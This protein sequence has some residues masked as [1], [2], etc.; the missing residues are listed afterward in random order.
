MKLFTTQIQLRSI[1]FFFILLV[2]LANYGQSTK[3]LEMAN[4]YYQNQSWDKAL[5]AY[6]GITKQN[7]YNG[8]YWFK[9]GS[10][11][12][13]LN[14]YESSIDSYKQAVL[15]G[16]D[17]ATASY[18]IA[19]SYA[20]INNAKSAIYWLNYAISNGL[21]N[22]EKLLASDTDLDA[23]RSE[24]GFVKMMAPKIS[25][26]IDRNTGW[27][28]DI[29]YMKN[30]FERTH[31]NLFTL[32]DKEKWE[33]SFNSLCK[34]IDNLNDYE[35]IVTLME[36]T[37]S[38]GAG[39]SLV[40]PPFSG[41]YHFGQLPIEFYQFSDGI[42]V[43]KAKDVYK[44]IIGLEVVSIE[45]IPIEEVL[46][47]VRKVANP[48]NE[49]MMN[50]TGLFYSTLPEVLL[51]YGVITDRSKVSIQLKD[52]NGDISTSVIMSEPFS[53]QVLQTK[54]LIDG[55]KSMNS[56][57]INVKPLY[58]K[59]TKSKYWHKYIK[60]SKLV[61]CQLNEIRNGK[62]Q[63]LQEYGKELVAFIENSDAMALVLDI[64]LNNGGN[65][66][67]NKDFLT[68]LIQCEKINQR[69]KFFTII[70]RKTFS[71][72]IMLTTQLDQYTETIFIG[73]PTG[74]KPSHIGDDNYFALPYS[75]L[76]VSAAMSYWQS[77]VSYDQ[78][79]WVAPEIFCAPSAKEYTDNIDPCLIAI[80][81]MV[82][83]Y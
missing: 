40:I 23:I 18:N 30:K 9:L 26:S 81:E 1:T 41:K 67:L 59:N 47:K 60:E 38:I 35:I 14:N 64:R 32:I 25:N 3:E 74:G 6:Q 36:I 39:H 54:G 73:E 68:Q 45:G 70:G 42:F 50:W 80:I 65:G 12:Y 11:N 13:N 16:Y 10:I 2:S 34:N 83:S 37:A 57:N 19:C 51:H 29:L 53:L 44:E 43:R 63:S 49:I 17:P 48:E 24:E 5:K 15:I 75:G 7:P 8:E 69:G 20:L 28:T 27:E 71:A 4:H 58:I 82:K 46:N 55:W 62:Q 79:N 52:C 78:R 77:H 76:M 22:R 21:K 66:L 56:E 61:Y 31:Y 33:L 72:A